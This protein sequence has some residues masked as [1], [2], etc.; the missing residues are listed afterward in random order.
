MK[1]NKKIV[2]KDNGEPQCQYFV[3]R[4][5]RL[6]RMTVRPGKQYC[7]E[8][9]P[10]PTAGDDQDTKRIPCPND[11]KHTCYASKLEKHLKICNAR[12]QDG[13]EYIIHNVNLGSSEGDYQHRPLTQVPPETLIGVVDKINSFYNEYLIDSITEATEK[14]I[15]SIVMEEFSEDGR[16]ESSRRHLRQVSSLLHLVEGAG[17]V[18]PNTCYID[19]GAGKGQLGVYACRTW[20]AGGGAG[21]G[22]VVLLE[23]AAL[24]HKR[25]RLAAPAPRDSPAPRASPAPRDSPALTRL[26]HDLAHVS[27]AHV[28]AVRAADNVVGL[29]KHLCGAATDFA[30]RALVAAQEAGGEGAGRV[31]GAVLATCCHHR[32]HPAHYVATHTL[33]THGFGA[34]ELDVLLGVVSWAT[35]GGGGAGRA[36][37]G[38]RAKAVLDW[39]RVQYL[40][41]RGFRARLVWFVSPRVTPENVCIVASR[42]AAAPAR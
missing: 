16:S 35:C 7:G 18:Q 37:T 19:L 28:P 15:H 6:C 20:T 36:E 23:R 32:V 22:G 34:E 39:G 14:P 12:H 33:Q 29:A 9:E 5:K 31:A 10:Q 21:G 1:D 17:L 8:H 4:K 30:L 27:L 42:E 11:P 38:R 2:L 24:R 40:R 26:R 3:L 25:D 13:P 41:E